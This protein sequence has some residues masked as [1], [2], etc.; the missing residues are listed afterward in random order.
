MSGDKRA[1][2]CCFS[3]TGS[4]I[5][6]ISKMIERVPDVIVTNKPV[7]K[8]DTINKKLADEYFDRILF[9]PKVPEFD[10]YVTAFPKDGVITLHGYLR[11]IPPEI[12]ESFEIYN[13]HPAPLTMYPE[14]KGKDPQKRI[15]ESKLTFGGNTIHR[16]TAE[17]DSGEI[18]SEEAFNVRGY[19]VDTIIALT[20]KKASYLWCTF[21]RDIL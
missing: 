9:L 5:Y 18:M 13:S 14:L 17:L 11:I 2:C 16:C 12:C 8:I 20:H 3:Q 4:E 19:D 15:Y 7:D 6:N 10:E 21:L 1:W